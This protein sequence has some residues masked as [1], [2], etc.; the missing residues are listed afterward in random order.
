MI[1]LLTRSL[2]NFT[3]AKPA[4]SAQT[5]TFAR[6]IP[7][8]VERTHSNLFQAVN[9]AID[10][11]LETDPT[12]ILLHLVLKSSEKMSSLVEFLGAPLDSAKNTGLIESS[13]LHLQNKES[14]DSPSE[15]Q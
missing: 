15:L 9:S 4:L 11:A 1:K 14:S 7:A 2:K 3:Q 10:I 8:S 13:T 12:Y 5:Y 6:D